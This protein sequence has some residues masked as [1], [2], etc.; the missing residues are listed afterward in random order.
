LTDNQADASEASASDAA[1]SALANTEDGLPAAGPSP[2]TSPLHSKT[3]D[4][5]ATVDPAVSS[6]MDKK[7]S[8]STLKEHTVVRISFPFIGCLIIYLFPTFFGIVFT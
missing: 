2:S 4:S 7:L 6:E 8:L 1:V 5:C 3:S